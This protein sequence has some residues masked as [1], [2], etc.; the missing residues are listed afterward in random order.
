M[1]MYNAKKG[2]FGKLNDRLLRKILTLSCVLLS[3]LLASCSGIEDM[4]A[5]KVTESD[6]ASIRVAVADEG[7]TAFPVL[8]KED[9]FQFKLTCDGTT[10]GVWTK[11]TKKNLSAYEVMNAD[12]ELVVKKG[13]HT[14]VLIGTQSGGATYSATITK[15]IA[16]DSELISFVLE[17][18]SV[19]NTGTGNA[20]ISVAYPV[21]D[22]KK[23]VV[24]RY[25]SSDVATYKNAP[26]AYTAEATDTNISG[27]YT[28]SESRLNAGEYIVEFVFYGEEGIVL[29]TWLEPIYISDNLDSN[30]TI[31]IGS[32]DA[33]YSI[34]YDED[35][36]EEATIVKKPLFYTWKTDVAL[37]VPTKEGYEFAGWY[38]AVD[39]WGNYIGSPIFAL[40]GA[41]LSGDL[42]LYASWETATFT[43]KF[44][45][46]GAKESVD[47]Q[48][49]EYYD[50]AT[51]PTEPERDGFAFSA[52]YTSDDD[53][54]T[55]ADEFGFGT[56]I[57]EDL[58]LY[59]RWLY[60]VK[61]DGNG[62]DDGEM[63]PVICHADDKSALRLAGNLFSKTDYTFLGWA[64]DKDAT[65]ATYADGGSVP[66]SVFEDGDTTLYAVWRDNNAE[67][68]LVSFE[69]DGGTPVLP[70]VVAD[71]AKASA[72]VATTKDGFTF[73]DWYTSDDDGVTLDIVYDFNRPVKQPLTLYAKWERTAWYVSEDGSDEPYVGDET[74]YGDGT[75][76]YPYA[77]IAKALTDINTVGSSEYDYEIVVS[78]RLLGSGTTT[79]IVINLSTDHAKSLTIRGATGNGADV[80]DSGNR[81]GSGTSVL[82]ISTKVP[83]ILKDIVITGG[84]TSN[85]DA[86]AGITVGSGSTLTLAS[87]A[88]VTGN[89][90]WNN[91]ALGAGGV[92][93][94]GTLYIEDGARI[95]QNT[96]SCSGGG[97]TLYKSSSAKVIMNGGE[98]SNNSA[99][100]DS[101]S[102]RYGGGVYVN[103]YSS[104]EMNGGEIS[105]NTASSGG[106]VYMSYGNVTLNDGAI[107]DN[108]V[109]GSGGGG[110][111]NDYGQLLMK[112]GSISGNV[113]AGY[114]GGVYNYSNYFSLNGG[115]ITGNTAYYGGGVYN[116]IYFTMN[117]GK[118][119]DNTADYGGGVYV[120]NTGFSMSGSAYIPAGK[121]GKNDVYVSS[122]S[123]YVKVNGAL[124]AESPVATITPSAYDSR[125][126][127][128]TDG[129][130]FDEE[131]VG[132]FALTPEY[133]N[134]WRIVADGYYGKLSAGVYT[135]T[136]KDV[137]GGELS[138][139]LAAES[140]A[141]H[142]F[143]TS[144]ALKDP[145]KDG[146]T[147][148]GWYIGWYE[149]GGKIL[150]EGAAL[151]SLG[152]RD[153]RS[154]ITLYAKW[155][156]ESSTVTIG[157]RDIAITL[158]TASHTLTASDGFTGYTW[159]VEGE[160]IAEGDTVWTVSDDGKVLT[161]SNDDLLAGYVYVVKVRAYDENG[162]LCETNKAVTRQ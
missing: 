93:V 66:A 74:A 100:Y 4:E 134:D 23:L 36:L 143:G 38:T 64:T 119:S 35:S 8:E 92:F 116:G 160:P 102:S 44:V 29:G 97:V 30:S 85:S 153:Y 159:L 105:G 132:K 137:G 111:Y 16:A 152:A 104:F 14:F 54:A 154:D 146:Y 73:I 71:K 69:T 157:E 161:F 12:E 95:T 75:F 109:S 62:A 125:N 86:G 110:I 28:Y 136:Y 20:G 99:G 144:T 80:L 50:Y 1:K 76:D 126:V 51:V 108:T 114:G 68:W 141:T 115:E 149:K 122:A 142:S 98:I 81:G 78:G 34:T 84:R 156:K 17:F 140:P 133:G 103:Q 127:L 88:I 120:C 57:E 131:T 129:L 130:P 158:D 94:S 42:T 31:E 91:S 148:M 82:S 112:G 65:E 60:N 26:V 135:I 25:K 3:F 52:W 89:T 145:T 61:F 83:V 47:E 124:T 10:L 32:F 39:E 33:I 138:G 72:P 24:T 5:P 56:P 6:T 27:N 162:V 58:T 150:T 118:I 18:A 2:H 49:V 37:P 41:Y 147:F 128:S 59:A 87:G 79:F 123:Y 90:Q 117:G 7:R 9:F 53:G 13:T 19:S 70:Q 63:E 113:S 55:L 67:G 121:D 46:D 101:L 15:D 106:G 21:K 77:T 48:T 107:S 22:V 11:D 43:V 155:V 151:T 139:T 40:Q 45:A 96:A